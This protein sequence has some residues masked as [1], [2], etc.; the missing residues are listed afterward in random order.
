LLGALWTILSGS[1][2][3]LGLGFGAWSQLKWGNE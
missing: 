3:M 1:G 2:V